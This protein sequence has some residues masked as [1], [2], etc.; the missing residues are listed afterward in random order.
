MS[1]VKFSF[2]LPIFAGASA[3]DYDLKNREL[4]G[5]IEAAEQLGYDS[6]WVPDHLNLGYRGEILEAWTVLAAASQLC[7]RMHLGGLVLCVSH[8]SPALLAKM[9]STLDVL[10]NGRVELGIGVGW[11]GSEQMSYGL[12]WIPS[13]RERVQ[14]LTEAVEIV[15]GMWT[16]D[17]FTYLGKYFKV[18]NAVCLPKPVQKP[19]PRIWIGGAGEKL[20]LKAVAKYADGW[21]IGNVPPEEYTHKLNVL[22]GHCKSVGT[23]YTNIE[24]S[25]DMPILITEKNSELEQVVKWSRWFAGISTEGTSMIPPVGDLAEMKQ[26]YILGTVPEVTHRI[27]EYVGAGVEH[28]MFEF[29]DFPSTNSMR[30][31]AENVIPSIS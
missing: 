14:Q 4:K 29:L 7:K 17:H 30:L 24:K 6:L 23:D 25:L 16:N 2:V 21:N 1:R 12:P 15:K 10:S 13:V 5:I 28:F 27:K 9:S 26:K 18:E 3:L 22:R 31:L 11:R 8:R 20:V 19:H